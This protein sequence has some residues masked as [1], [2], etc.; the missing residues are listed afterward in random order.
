MNI[1]ELTLFL[2]KDN[3]KFGNIQAT[4]RFSVVTNNV[5]GLKY[6]DKNVEFI[7]VSHHLH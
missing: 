4:E 5:W 6:K 1:G 7:V 2:R 3:N